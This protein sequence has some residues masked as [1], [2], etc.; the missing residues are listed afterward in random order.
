MQLVHVAI[1]IASGGDTTASFVAYIANEC[2]NNE[3]YHA[4]FSKSAAP[5]AI[6]KSESLCLSVSLS[7]SLCLSLSKPLNTAQVFGQEQR[8]T[9]AVFR[10]FCLLGSKD[11]VFHGPPNRGG[12]REESGKQNKGKKLEKEWMK[13]RGERSSQP[14]NTFT[15][16]GCTYA[17]L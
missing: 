8:N 5:P 10:C 3:H 6:D 16:F 14:P 17:S 2:L 1:T 12:K 9:A 7:L 15:I 13:G 4:S 11:S